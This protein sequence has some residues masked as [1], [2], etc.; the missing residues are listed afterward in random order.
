MP[1]G[2]EAGFV[3][4][5]EVLFRELLNH[6]ATDTDILGQLFHADSESRLIVAELC[7]FLRLGNPPDAEET[8]HMINS[9]RVIKP[10]RSLEPLTPPSKA[11]ALHFRPAERR[12]SPILTA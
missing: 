12:E 3:G 11:V 5:Q 6:A 8:K 9:K 7:R 2:C 4:Y 10:R 1:H